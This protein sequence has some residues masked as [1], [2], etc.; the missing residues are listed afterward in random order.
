VRFYSEDFDLAEKYVAY[1]DYFGF[2][3]LFAP[4]WWWG[5]Y[6]PP[7]AENWEVKVSKEGDQNKLRETKVVKTPDGNLREVVDY[8]RM[9]P[10]LNV[11]TKI[12]I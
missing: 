2:D 6:I 1:H 11:L 12:N 7:S 4:G 3:V 8:A 5:N 9:S 10:Y